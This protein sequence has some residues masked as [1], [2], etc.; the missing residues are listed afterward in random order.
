LSLSELTPSEDSLRVLDELPAFRAMPEDVRHV[1][2]EAFEPVAYDFGQVIVREGEPAEAFYVIVSGSARVL[3]SAESG[4]EVPLNL[5]GRGESF[6]EMGLLTDSTRTA[7]V[8]ASGR[9]EALRLDRDTFAEM[10]R[11]HPAVRAQFQRIADYRTIQNFLRL[12]SAFA[13]LP[14]DGLSLI[15]ASLEPVDVPAGEIVV[16]EGDPAGPMYVI[17][18]GRLRAF[19]ERDGHRDDINY[20]RKGDSFGELSVLEGRPRTASVEA[21]TPSRLL[22]LTPEL[23][24][25]LLDRY[26]EFRRRLEERAVQLESLPVARVPLDFAEILPAET[27]V[28]AVGPDQVEETEIAPVDADAAEEF[29]AEDLRPKRRWWRRRNYPHVYQL[30]EMDCGAACL[31]SV[32]RYFGRPV[33]LPRI[34]ELVHTSVDGTSLLGIARGAEALG[35][36]ARTVRASKSNLD[37]LPLPAIVHWEGNHWVVLYEVAENHV[38]IDDPAVGI[39]KIDRGDFEKKWTGYAALLSPTPAFLELPKAQANTAWL[40]PFLRPHRGLLLKA[41]GLALIA[42]ALEL[43]IP[44]FTQVVVDDAIPNQD[45]QLLLVILLGMLGVLVVMVGA[46]VLQRYLFAFVAVR[47]DTESLDFLTAKLLSLPMSYFTTRRTGDIERRLSGIRELRQFFIESGVAALTA[48]TQLAAALV[49]MFVYSWELALVYLALAPLYA[50]LMRFSSTRLRPMFDSLE[51]AF[52]RYGSQQI[53]SIRGIETVKASAAEEGMRQMMLTRFSQIADKVFRSEFLIM[54][55]QG[56]IQMVTFL[57][58]ALFL[59]V[60][61]LLVIDGELS[62]GRFVAFNA[63]IAL[64][65]GPVLILLSLWDDLQYG[66]ILLDRLND[67]VEQEPEQGE[68]HAA[69]RTVTTLEGAVRLRNVGFRYGGPEAPA[70]LE[71]ID[72]DVPPGTTVAIV[73]RSGSGKS[74]LVKCLAGLLEP[75]DGRIELDHVDLTTLDYRSVRRH[76]GVVLQESYLFDDTIGRNIAFGEELD[77][78]RVIWASKLANAHDFVQRLPLGY[79]T[80]IGESGLRLSGGQAQRIAIARAVYNRPAILLLDEASSSLDTESERLVKLNLDELL[81]ERTSFVIAHRLST[82]RDADM[83]V[84]LEKG[85]LV[86][87]G[88][89]SGLMERRGL[90]HYL[91][92]QQVES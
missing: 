21:L 30:D 18:D 56:A 11:W 27:E 7:T 29:E 82:V 91:V 36:D 55:Y 34:R 19:L 37:S 68:D 49:L 22:R 40:K 6:G 78:A 65:N 92:S 5:L 1:L 77:Q 38:R 81:R 12:H 39:R 66:R 26:P 44:I 4:E 63:L 28:A 84:V 70:I 62:L 32:T 88:T 51:E 53:D 71:G 46:T 3:K 41:V 86:E 9:V 60:G 72:L 83:I 59:F 31:G 24:A 58:L 2:G 61:G 75:T 54:N 69:L 48:V 13:M 20:L 23:F 52:G 42:A 67:V 16:R 8:R 57:S 85:R 50:V 25:E 89:H 90:Y 87:R 33:S 35:L 74:T 80:R 45:R 76:I 14:V 73:G 15:A 79:D 64:A 17:E 10:T 47:I 43:V